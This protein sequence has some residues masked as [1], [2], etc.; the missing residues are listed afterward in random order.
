M[1]SSNKNLITVT[2][3]FFFG[4]AAVFSFITAVISLRGSS[5]Q[6]SASRWS[7]P[8]PALHQPL[9]RR[10]VNPICSVLSIFRAFALFS[11][12]ERQCLLQGTPT[13]I[14]FTINMS[15]CFVFHHHNLRQ[16]LPLL[17]HVR[18][19]HHTA[20][21]ALVSPRTVFFFPSHFLLKDILNKKDHEE[22]HTD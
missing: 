3:F 12:T 2:C 5:R 20:S 18:D 21:P 19:P 8:D 16:S 17:P 14:C 15:I 1:S 22:N 4:S 13:I 11:T 6:H 7:S 10:C 9:L